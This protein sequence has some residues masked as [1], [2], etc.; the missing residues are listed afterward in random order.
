MRIVKLNPNPVHQENF[1]LVY[2]RPLQPIG[3][4]IWQFAG[5]RCLNCDRMVKQDSAMLKHKVNCKPHVRVY[6]TDDPQIILNKQRTK[7]VPY[8]VEMIQVLPQLDNIKKD[9]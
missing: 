2:R 1:H 7:W 9:K 5:Y 4:S 3:D 6:N 8:H